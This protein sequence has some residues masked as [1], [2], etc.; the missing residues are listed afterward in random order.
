VAGKFVVI[1]GASRGIG[2]A[3]AEALAAR[4]ATVLGTSRDATAVPNPPSS[5]TLVDLDITDPASV[6]AFPGAIAAHPAFPGAIDVLINNAGRFVFGTPIPLAPPL[7]PLFQAGVDEAMETLYAGHV[8]VTNTLLPF[9]NVPSGD[10]RIMFT[11]SIVAY[12]VGG[13][14]VGEATGQSFLSAYYSGKRALLAYANNLRG[15]FRTLGLPIKVTTVNPFAI[16][17]ALAE[18]LNPIYLEPVDGAGNTTNPGLQAVLD[19]TRFFLANGIPVEEAGRA[20]TQLLETIDPPPNVVVGFAEGPLAT[21]GATE[22]ILAGGLAENEESAIT[23]AADPPGGR[24]GKGRGR[25]R[26]R[27]R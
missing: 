22:N 25:G 12:S 5:F 19:G 8:R 24:G 1:T 2:R 18:G 20:F 27:R 16:R 9:M 15:G 13:S 10:A 21:A 23:F 26:G 14:E 3:T 6:A 7:A 11:A 17:T 4:G